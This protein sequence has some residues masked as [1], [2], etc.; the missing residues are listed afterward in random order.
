M[1]SG[2]KTDWK[3]VSVSQVPP[4]PWRI[5]GDNNHFVQARRKSGKPA[6]SG[7]PKPTL[8]ELR[9]QRDQWLK[10]NTNASLRGG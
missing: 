4:G 9:E 5:F 8:Q 2:D 10:R 6:R 3:F 7:L 1:K